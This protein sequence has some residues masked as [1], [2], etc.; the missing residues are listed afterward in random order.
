V[1]TDLPL[2]ALPLIRPRAWAALAILFALSILYLGLLTQGQELFDNDY[3]WITEAQQ[4]WLHILGEVF[5]PI[6]EGWGFQTRPVQVACFKALHQTFGDAPLPYYA[7]KSGLFGLVTIGVAFFCLQGGLK[8]RAA[9]SAASMFALSAPVYAS[10]L[11]ISDFELLAQLFMLAA[12]GSLLRLEASDLFRSSPVA[13]RLAQVGILLASLLGHRTKGSAKLI[14]LVIA[15]YLLLHHRDAIKRNIPLIGAIALTVLPIFWILESP[16]P[17]FAPFAQDQSQGWMWKPASLTGIWLLLVGNAHL[18]TGTTGP[19]AVHSL[20]GTLL[21]V[22]LWMAVIAGLLMLL[23]RRARRGSP[24]ALPRPVALCGIWLLVA[25]LSFASYPSL[26]IGFMARYV[27]SAL[28]PACVLVAY[29]VCLAIEDSPTRLRRSGT[30][31]LSAM[32]LTHGL[33]NFGHVRRIRESLGQIVVLC[34]RARSDIS[35][36]VQD[37]TVVLLGLPYSYRKPLPDGNVYLKDPGD[38]AQMDPGRPLYIL[39]AH[40][41]IADQVDHEHAVAKALPL[42]R[43]LPDVGAGYQ[44]DI[45]PVKTF[46]GLTDSLYD[47]WIHASRRSFLATL[48]KINLQPIGT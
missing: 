38:L 45:R 7:F 27:T 46:D 21:P 1:T 26:P 10:A 2:P 23:N 29:V 6:P 39:V 3:D 8:L 19:E 33:C 18:L 47:R 31:L 13:Y 25:V 37:A 43:R 12:F 48:L 20:L 28:I 5:R 17:P 14:P 35:R 36:T 4:P 30:V 44:V 9:I 15:L 40:D 16:I 41:G 24:G 11:W 22:P 34:H 32:V 42:L